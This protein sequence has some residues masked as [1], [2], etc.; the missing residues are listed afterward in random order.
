MK[1]R[2]RRE[3]A[4]LTQMELSRRTGVPATYISQAEVGSRH[5]DLDSMIA[6]EA[7]LG[8]IDWP[9]N[10]SIGEKRQ[11]I[12]AAAGLATRYP[13]AAVADFLKEVLKTRSPVQTLRVYAQ[14]VL[15]ARE[16]LLPP[17]VKDD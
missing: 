5:L 13:M 11:I 17:G 2:Q 15:G 4:G 1:L 10:F 16:S 14:G 7:E 6:L 3:L 8:R 12:Q 9:D